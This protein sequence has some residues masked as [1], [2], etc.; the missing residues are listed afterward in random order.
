[1]KPGGIPSFSGHGDEFIK[2]CR[3]ILLLSKKSMPKKSN[4]PQASFS[5]LLN[6]SPGLELAYFN[7]ALRAFLN[8]IG[9]LSIFGKSL[10]NL[11]SYLFENISTSIDSGYLIMISGS[12]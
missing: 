5:T 8:E 6:S 11:V 1:M 10:T 2:F 4:S 12:I 3:K 7:S 9:S